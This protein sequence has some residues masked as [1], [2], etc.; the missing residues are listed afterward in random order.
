MS[1]N[2]RVLCR[3]RPQNRVE[4]EHN[5]HEV[6]SIQNGT[7]ISLAGADGEKNFNFDSVYDPSVDQATVFQDAALPTILDLFKGYNGTIFVYG[8]TGSGKTHTMM[9]PDGGKDMDNPEYKGIVPRMINTIFDVV[10]EAPEEIEFMVKCSYI[11][12]Y[13]EKIRDLLDQA[14]DNLRVREDKT[15]GVWIEGATEVY[16]A[17]PQ[18]VLEVLHQGV[19]NRAVAATKMNA[20]SSRSHSVF[21]L[22]VMQ[23]NL[24]S[25][26]SV[27]GKLYFV[28]LAGS[29]KVGKTGASGQTLEEAKTINKSL[30]ALGNVINALTDGKSKHI[31][32]RDSKLT[33]ILQESLG[34]NSRTTLVI[35]CS[36]SSYNE[37]E[38]ISTLR[39]GERA[40]TIKNRAKLNIE[41]SAAELQAALD[42]ANEEILQLKIYISGLEEELFTFRGDTPS[43]KLFKPASLTDGSPMTL[44]SSASAPSIARPDQLSA[45]GRHGH[46]DQL[47]ELTSKISE[48][49]SQNEQF[50]AEQDRLR[51]DLLEKETTLEEKLRDLEALKQRLSAALH[52]EEELARNKEMLISKVA[53]LG[54]TNE[55]LE[56]LVKEKEISIENLTVE[57]TSLV[58]QA[59]RFKLQIA[60]LRLSASE[61]AKAEEREKLKES[62]KVELART[63]E[64]QYSTSPPSTSP[65]ASRRSRSSS[66]HFSAS[67]LPDITGEEI[68]ADLRAEIVRLQAENS[69]LT[70]QLG[71]APRSSS[72][73]TPPT[74]PAATAGSTEHSHALQSHLM[75][76][77]AKLQNFVAETERKFAEFEQLKL[78]LVRD[79]QNRCEKVIDLE[80][81]LDEFREKHETLVAKSNNKELIHKNTFLEKNLELL[82]NSHHEIVNQTNTLRLENQIAG[83]KLELRDKRIEQLELQ[84][85]SADE[86]LKAQ[87]DE[88]QRLKDQLAARPVAPAPIAPRHSP[89][90]T[91][92]ARPLRGGTSSASSTTSASTTGS[93]P[94]TGIWS[95]I[96]RN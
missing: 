93:K 6:V 1:N 80:V 77:E 52:V 82:T 21:I 33:R 12:I 89:Q 73:T 11:E 17:C 38:T 53:E 76:A 2:I 7:H 43:I 20:E 9:G 19:S 66:L 86:R 59:E 57:N 26:G 15:H 23:K 40:K 84:V 75:M 36:P 87:A 47:S 18:D 32:Y 58:Q 67:S 69:K 22:T 95:L 72:A 44:L 68:A 27:N 92:I 79:L 28:D 16:V 71:V 14:K 81:L 48:L 50:L 34:G 51:D 88:I 24:K 62:K 63:L 64:I 45:G 5:G 46:L 78:N 56:Y 96:S 35:N 31:P 39:F 91:R 54:L 4:K 37:S 83:K 8:Q 25:G 74:G 94:K 42:R 10:A 55:R 3:F 61:S 60:E 13:M 85:Q 65:L 70:A 41:R 90:L 30:S 29:E 49:E